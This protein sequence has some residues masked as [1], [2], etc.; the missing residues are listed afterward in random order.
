MSDQVVVTLLF[1]ATVRDRAGITRAELVLPKHATVKDL[2]TK[3]VEAYP[4]I[5]DAIPS[6]LVAINRE[7]ALDEDEVPDGAEVA[8]FP[9]VSGGK[10]SDFP[11]VIAI[12][13]GEIDFDGIVGKITTPTVG[14]ICIFTGVVR[15][16]TKREEFEETSYINYEAYPPMADI[17]MRQIAEEIRIRWP[18]V[19]GIAIVQRVGHLKPGTPTVM[20]AC[21]AA[22]RDD[23]IFEAARYGIDR[24]KEIVPVWK[25]EISPQGQRWVEGE[26]IPRPGD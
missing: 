2:K 15:A 24:L 23:S 21:S 18:D 6:V 8:M 20:V 17:K 10:G 26:Y 16:I 9:P 14:A 3:V 12:M 13:E 19:E 5:A 11:V 7:F 22:H 4:S 25:Q 1:F